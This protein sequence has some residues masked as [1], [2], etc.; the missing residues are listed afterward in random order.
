M[1]DPVPNELT[2]LWH[3]EA[4]SFPDGRRDISTRVFWLQTRGLFADIR[5]RADRPRRVEASGFA[6]YDDAELI[7][8]AAMNGFAGAFEVDGGFCRWRRRLDFHPPGG[9]PDEANC[10]LDGDLLIETGTGGDYQE[11]WRHA[12]PP[13]A[14]VTSFELAEDAA[15]PGRAGMLVLAGDHFIQIVD[16]PE[17]LPEGASLATLVRADLEAGARDRAIGRLAMKI[18][19]GRIER[20][21]EVALSTFPWLESTPLFAGRDCRFDA[22]AGMVEVAGGTGRQLWRLVDTTLPKTDLAAIFPGHG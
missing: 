2:G 3:R 22:G 18:A 17:P 6:D 8:L 14:A 19:Y 9:P 15:Q 16:R 11:N 21:W 20:G 7:K 12:T 10:V 13:G 1:S 5:I 4:I